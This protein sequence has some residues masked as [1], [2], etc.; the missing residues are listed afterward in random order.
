MRPSLTRGSFEMQ[1]GLGV[2]VLV[3]LV[4]SCA[5][6]AE[7]REPRRVPVESSARLTSRNAAAAHDALMPLRPSQRRQLDGRRRKLSS[8]TL[9]TVTKRSQQIADIFAATMIKHEARR[10]NEEWR[11]TMA[12]FRQMRTGVT[13][14][15]LSKKAVLVGDL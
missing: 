2:R 4:A 7:P 6:V 1:L 10:R 8:E 11:R 13:L 14:Q 12:S 5:V 15:D 9:P 3:V